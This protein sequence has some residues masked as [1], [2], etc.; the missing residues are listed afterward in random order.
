MLSILVDLGFGPNRDNNNTAFIIISTVFTG[1]LLRKSFTFFML[2]Y[3]I[4][5]LA[6]EQEYVIFTNVFVIFIVENIYDNCFNLNK[7]Q[8]AFSLATFI[9]FFFIYSF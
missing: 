4:L 1:V 5:F 6:I 9:S 2:S 8:I 3:F 7:Y